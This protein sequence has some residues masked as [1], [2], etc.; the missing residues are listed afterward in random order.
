MA[1]VILKAGDVV[2]PA[3]VSM[4][5]GN[6]LIWSTD[7]GRTISGKMMGDVIA[8]KKTLTVSWGIL[9]ETEYNLIKNNLVKGFFPVSFRTGKETL[10]TIES[11]RGTITEEILGDI[12]DGNFYYKSAGVDI[13]QR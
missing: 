2:L 10:A 8:E 13:V 4:S 1:Q 7:T 6:E 3:P 11:Y 5:V 9:E 12:G